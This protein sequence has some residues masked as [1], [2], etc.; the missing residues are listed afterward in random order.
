M[1]IVSTS[2]TSAVATPA[3]TG[4]KIKLVST[5]RA[6][7]LLGVAVRTFEQMKQERLPYFPNPVRVGCG[8]FW[9]PRE[10]EN[11]KQKTVLLA[12]GRKPR[13]RPRKSLSEIEIEV[14]G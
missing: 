5:A 1:K 2:H 12:S 7:E 11:F 9:D 4:V 10:L 3:P 14:V 13:G 8:N 6:A